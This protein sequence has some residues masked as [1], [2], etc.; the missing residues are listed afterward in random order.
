MNMFTDTASAPHSIL[1]IVK[2]ADGIEKF[3]RE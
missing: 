3:L 1:I 2:V